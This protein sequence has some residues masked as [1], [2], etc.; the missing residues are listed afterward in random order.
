MFL[1]ELIGFIARSFRNFFNSFILSSSA[2]I[3]DGP[4]H[5]STQ[6][7]YSLMKSTHFILFFSSLK[8][9]KAKQLKRREW[10]TLEAEWCCGRGAEPITHSNKKINLFL[11]SNQSTHSRKVDWWMKRKDK[12]KRREE[13]KW[14]PFLSFPLLSR[15]VFIQLN[16]F[17]F[18]SSAP[19][20]CGKGERKE[21]LVGGWAC[22]GLSSSLRS[23]AACRRH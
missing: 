22:C 19:L 21:K 1:V 15:A 17:N 4:Q 5:N 3:C 7:H 11:Q 10:P 18:S 12:W 23:I 9:A 20:H 14:S 8:E 13:K 2:V 16:K 6:L